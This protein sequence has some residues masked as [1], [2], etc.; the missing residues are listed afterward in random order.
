V[1]KETPQQQ[2]TNIAELVG[3]LNAGVFEQQI[4]QALSDI[5]AHVCTTGKKGELTLRFTLKQIGDSNQVAMTH[6]LKAV[7]PK[8]RGKLTE[9]HAT[10]TPLHVGPGG[11]LTLFPNTQTR[12]E[13]GAGAATG[14]TDGVR[15]DG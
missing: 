12:M 9:E 6:A 13:L 5:A 11:K 8:Q 10:D 1:G 4:N 3:E 2:K 14:R 15:H 7:V